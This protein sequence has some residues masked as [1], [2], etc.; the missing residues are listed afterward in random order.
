M[1]LREVEREADFYGAMDGASKFVRGDAIAAIIIVTICILGGFAKGMLDSNMTLGEVLQRYTLLTIGDGLGTQI[2][3]LLLSTATG[4]VVM[5]YSA[6]H[7][8]ASFTQ[9]DT[10][11]FFLSKNASSANYNF[12]I[13]AV[14]V[15][16]SGGN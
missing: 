3:A 1:A 11:G 5:T 9:F 15:L 6:T 2:P 4:I 16:L 7:T 14:D 13:K 10:A 8:A 12:I